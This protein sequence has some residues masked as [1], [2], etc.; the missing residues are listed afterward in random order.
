[1]R[2]GGVLFLDLSKHV[3]WVYGHPADNAV[4]LWGV[5][6]LPDGRD[7]GFI[8]N[9]VH[10]AIDDLLDEH[11]PTLVGIEDIIP[12][13]NN[14]VHTARLTGGIHAIVDLA[15]YQREIIPQREHVD[16]LRSAVIGRCRLSALEKAV[17]PRLSVKTQIVEPWC[18]AHG[19]G[20]IDSHDA[21][22]AAI[23][24]AY[25]IGVRAERKPRGK[26]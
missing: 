2:P 22:D 21:R 7:Y 16:H 18:R 19:W 6:E 3:G 8:F 10:N 23:G 26:R 15:L 5:R 4:P 9:S 13:R 25:L 20:E 14:N 24:F 17:R 12:Q 1:M 11:Q